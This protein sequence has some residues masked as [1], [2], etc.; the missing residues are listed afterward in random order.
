M[1]ENNESII[2]ESI[3]SAEVEVDDLIVNSTNNFPILFGS[4]ILTLKELQSA[5]KSSEELMNSLETKVS[6]I[7]RNIEKSIE[8]NKK[9]I[10]DL[11]LKDIDIA[12]N[13]EIHGTLAVG[14][15]AVD[16]LNGIPLNALND[17]CSNIENKKITGI[18]SFPTINI[19]RDNL[20]VRK[21][22]GIPINNIE[23]DN[24]RR[25][26]TN[27]DF[28]KISKLEVGKNLTLS[29]LMSIDW[30][31]LMKNLVLKNEEKTISG[32][33]TILGVRIFI[34]N[35]SKCEIYNKR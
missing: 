27:I 6:E 29:K 35:N 18:K 11:Y 30:N 15:L 31:N 4:G 25:N 24:V 16:R 14:R 28:S 21:I 7:E 2:R 23:F 33:T 8:I 19:K 10:A 9:N 26:Y 17:Q 3:N 13:L 22:N 20:V 34:M 1:S 5:Y 12:G 32:V